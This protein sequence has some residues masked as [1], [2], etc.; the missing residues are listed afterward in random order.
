VAADPSD[1]KALRTPSTEEHALE[2]WGLTV[3]TVTAKSTGAIANKIR[4]QGANCAGA[5]SMLGKFDS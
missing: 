3:H 1:P 5:W 2:S 4:C